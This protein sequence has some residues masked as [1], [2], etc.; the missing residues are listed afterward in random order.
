MKPTYQT[1]T[2]RCGHVAR[3]KP[4]SMG[5][6]KARAKR[7]AAKRRLDCRDCALAAAFERAE[8]QARS[9]AQFLRTRRVVSA[10]EERYFH[11]EQREKARLRIEKLYLWAVSDDA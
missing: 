8:H 11:E 10:G 5:R 7:I 9:L 3:I 1:L 6:G 4:W 2:H